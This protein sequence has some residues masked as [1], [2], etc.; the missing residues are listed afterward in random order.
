MPPTGTTTSAFG[1]AFF[2]SSWPPAPWVRQE[3]CRPADEKLRAGLTGVGVFGPILLHKALPRKLSLIFTVLK[4][5][6]TGVI[7][8]TAFVHVRPCKPTACLSIIA[9][10]DKLPFKLFT[11]ASLMFGNKCLGDLEYEGT[12]AATLMAGIFLSFLVEYIG[13]RIILSKTRATPSFSPETRSDLWLS[14]EIVSILVMEAGILFHSLR[15]PF[16]PIL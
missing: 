10:T 9:S 1:L 15:K 6:G 3:R 16:L 8:S 5:F 13:Q 11:H 4:Q 2:L 7:I 12:A 14:T